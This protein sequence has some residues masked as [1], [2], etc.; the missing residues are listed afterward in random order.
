[1]SAFLPTLPNDECYYIYRL[2][3]TVRLLSILDFTFGLLMFF[4][5]YIGFYIIFRLL[6][7]ISGYYGAKQYDYCLTSLY[8]VFL[9]LGTIGELVIIYIYQRLHTDG[10]IN[11]NTLIFGIIY[12]C[13]F[14]FLK[15]YITRFVYIFTKKVKKLG[16]STKLDL[17][18]Y[19]N[20][21]VQIIYW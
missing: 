3:K 20:Q 8:L 14:F 5:G 16:H 18:A 4:F 9:I 21:P 19:D 12:Q 7:A 2:S 17:V 6:C 15:A 10:K 13:L 1:M 11:N